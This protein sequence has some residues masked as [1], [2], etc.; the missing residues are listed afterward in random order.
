MIKKVIPHVLLM[1]FVLASPALAVEG[2]LDALKNLFGAVGRAIMI[3]LPVLGL[4]QIGLGIRRFMQ[5][6][7]GPNQGKGAFGKIILGTLLVS[8]KP[9]AWSI[10]YTLQKSGFPVG[11][12]QNIVK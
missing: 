9:V 4:I 5:G 8:I 7:E 10:I 2:I 3:V 6:N 12:L 11:E 1:V